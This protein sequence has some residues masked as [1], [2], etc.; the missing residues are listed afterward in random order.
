MRDDLVQVILHAEDKTREDIVR[1]LPRSIR[2]TL[3]AAVAR[4][5]FSLQSCNVG[6]VVGDDVEFDNSDKRL[7]DWRG[8]DYADIHLVVRDTGNESSARV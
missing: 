7:I 8:A 4:R 2:L 6:V 1:M 5:L 3:V